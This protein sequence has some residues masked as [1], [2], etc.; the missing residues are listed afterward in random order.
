[1]ENRAHAEGEFVYGLSADNH[2]LDVMNADGLLKEISVGI[3]K[4]RA[5]A[6]A[7]GLVEEGFPIADLISLSFYPKKEIAFRAAW[8]L[9]MIAERYPEAFATAA[10]YFI[11]RYPG[12]K[13][14]ELP[15]A[16]YKHHDEADIGSRLS[17][18]FSANRYGAGSG[19]N[20]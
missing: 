3:G 19:S 5:A 15:P 16:F 11:G 6:L 17:A 8:I 9:E 7:K 18:S 10:A 13:Q 2:N 12:T 4:V 14:S 1:M 20:V